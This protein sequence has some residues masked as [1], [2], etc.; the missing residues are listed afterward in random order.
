MARQVDSRR[1]PRR[2]GHLDKMLPERDWT[3][4]AEQAGV[5]PKSTKEIASKIKLQ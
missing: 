4:Y 3:R 2:T 5:S 1:P